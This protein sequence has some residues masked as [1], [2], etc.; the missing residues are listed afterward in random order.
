MNSDGLRKTLSV[1]Y[2]C[3]TEVN[4]SIS[5]KRGREWVRVKTIQATVSPEL[6]VTFKGKKNATVIYDVRC[7]FFH[8]PGAFVDESLE[9]VSQIRT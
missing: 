8:L 1:N 6:P 5:P 4:S 7:P 9:Q 2:S 3:R